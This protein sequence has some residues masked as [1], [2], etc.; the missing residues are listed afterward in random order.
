M[1]DFEEF[2]DHVNTALIYRELGLSD[3]KLRESLKEDGLK[4]DVNVDFVMK[5]I[6]I[7]HKECE[8]YSEPLTGILTDENLQDDG[9]EDVQKYLL[10]NNVSEKLIDIIHTFMIFKITL[11]QATM[12]IRESTS[13]GKTEDQIKNE[14]SKLGLDGPMLDT[15]YMAAVTKIGNQPESKKSSSWIRSIIWGII[16]L[17]L[18]LWATSVMEGD[19]IYY[20]AMIVGGIMIF[21]GLLKMA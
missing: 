5:T 2:S 21:R 10:Q 17:G 12:I 9:Y 19:V 4:D 20:G 6:D 7:V 14:L 13:Q 3:E 16:W 18:G 11:T 8:K 15:I 1:S